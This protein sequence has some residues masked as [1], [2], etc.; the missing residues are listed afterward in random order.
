MFPSK[1]EYVYDVVTL[2]FPILPEAD[3]NILVSSVP[4]KNGAN[5]LVT[6]V[7]ETILIVG[8]VVSITRALL[9]AKEPEAP[10][11]DKVRVA[12]FPAASLI[13]PPANDSADVEAKSRS[14]AVS[15]D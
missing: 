3:G 8:A 14:L 4:S 1:P 6:T 12:L 9:S 7:S 5:C 11:D 10:G 2:V 13:V 15:P